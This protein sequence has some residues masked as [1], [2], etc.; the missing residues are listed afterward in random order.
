MNNLDNLKEQIRLINKALVIDLEEIVFRPIPISSNESEI[1][2]DYFFEK[3]YSSQ[4]DEEEIEFSIINTERLTILTGF[5]GSGKTTMLMK[6]LND[7]RHNDVSFLL[8][9]FDKVLNL[10]YNSKK[11]DFNL[12]GTE[13]IYQYVVNRLKSKFYDQNKSLLNKL[14]KYLLLPP[15]DSEFEIFNKFY[16]FRLEILQLYSKK[17]Q[18][19][20]SKIE[21]WLNET[22][23]KEVETIIENVKKEL[24]IKHLIFGLYHFKICSKFILIFDNF[25]KIIEENKKDFLRNI[26]EIQNSV[27]P[28]SKCVIVISRENLPTIHS[29]DAENLFFEQVRIKVKKYT[30]VDNF[31]FM[32]Q[33]AYLYDIEDLLLRRLDTA[34][35]F[36]INKLTQTK[37]SVPLEH[38]KKKISTE[39]KF[40][41]KITEI[42]SDIFFRN[43]VYPF[44]G[45][46]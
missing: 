40:I 29:T 33:K 46:P 18:K 42:I 36:Y 1:S 25:D 8:L 41:T 44:K 10:L 4:R 37:I 43:E 2:L 6:V 13:Y 45:I 30:K 19:T 22:K 27:E 9:D 5:R 38:L 11:N 39:W 20:S 14:C 23:D 15:K 3:I 21:D 17:I 28:I 26:V 12:L 31:R 16:K 24:E 34:K 32:T 7:I 35:E